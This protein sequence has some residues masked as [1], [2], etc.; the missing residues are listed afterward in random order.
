MD[1]QFKKHLIIGA[2]IVGGGVLLIVAYKHLQGGGSAANGS[3]ESA[4]Q[5]A[6]DQANQDALAYEEVSSLGGEED[7]GTLGGSETLSSP[8]SPTTLASELQGLEAAL[9][10]VSPPSSPSAGGQATAPTQGS[11]VP[12][13]PVRIL[14][15]VMS[16][17]ESSAGPLPVG[18][19]K[20]ALSFLD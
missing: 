14:P 15:A 9:N 17:P 4:A 11:G 20:S 10:V 16:T 19:S 6:Q 1:A 13:S 18:A 8:S 12:P 3:S 5:A 7:F 2:V